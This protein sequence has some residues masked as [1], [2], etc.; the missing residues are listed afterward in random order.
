MTR[1]PLCVA[2]VVVAAGAAD[3]QLPLP[4]GTKLP[5]IAVVVLANEDL[6]K[7]LKLTDDQKKGLKELMDKA[8]EA[9]TLRADALATTP[10]DRAKLQAWNKEMT[11]LEKD[12]PPAVE[13]AIT[14]DQRKRMRQVDAQR[15]GTMAWGEPAV[16]RVLKL[17]DKQLAKFNAIQDE[18]VKERTALRK[19]YGLTQTG[20]PA[21]RLKRPTDEQA[22]EYVKKLHALTDDFVAK[23]KK[24]LTAD[25]QKAWQ[26]AVGEPFDV[27]KFY[28]K[29]AGK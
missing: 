19:E 11:K 4:D 10:P 24:E 26:E 16:S 6:Q 25:Q 9:D 21:N 15:H 12:G 13:K 28:P 7:E 5:S 18:F 20:S 3:A 14:D 22:A 27:S 23:Q 1:W 29:P 8:A 17:T 2:A